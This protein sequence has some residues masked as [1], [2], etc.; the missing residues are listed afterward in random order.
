MAQVFEAHAMRSPL[1]NDAI[2]ASTK[3]RG[4]V[5]LDRIAIASYLSGVGGELLVSFSLFS[6]RY[7]TTR[8]KA[9]CF[10]IDACGGEAFVP[11]NREK[12][13]KEQ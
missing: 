11:R 3:Q 6:L 5:T 1:D 2:N 9:R 12:E 10:G 7:L 13:G 4:R 8:D